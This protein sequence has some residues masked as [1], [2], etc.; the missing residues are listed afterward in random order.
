MAL[1]YQIFRHE[2]KMHAE[3]WKDTSKSLRLNEM[4]LERRAIKV[5]ADLRVDNEATLS[6]NVPDTL[7]QCAEPK[8]E[9]IYRLEIA[10]YLSATTPADCKR[11]K[12][13]SSARAAL[14]DLM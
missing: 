8:S 14:W 10:R 7:I 13:W 2:K 5:M 6:F 3:R 12:S 1:P 4:K 11:G 9:H